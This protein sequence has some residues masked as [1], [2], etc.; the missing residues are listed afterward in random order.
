M[1]DKE[2]KEEEDKEAL[3][4]ENNK[5]VFNIGFLYVGVQNNMRE[6]SWKQSC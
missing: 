5:V 6:K 1:E 4:E 3:I 2:E